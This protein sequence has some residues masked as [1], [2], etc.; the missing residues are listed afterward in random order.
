V[1]EYVEIDNLL[2]TSIIKCDINVWTDLYVNIVISGETT[3]FKEVSN[4]IDNEITSLT[5]IAMKIK[6][7][8]SENWNTKFVLEDLFVLYF[9]HL[10]NDYYSRWIIR[11]LTQICSLKKFLNISFLLFLA[12][13]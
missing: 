5:P 7:I 12:L 9:Q 1:I 13:I 3:I 8:E 10:N 6:V 11:K 2:F 4:Q